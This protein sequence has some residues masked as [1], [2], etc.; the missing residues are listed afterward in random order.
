M[1][2]HF[3][4]K[5]TGNKRSEVVTIY[6]QI[7]FDNINTIVEPFCGSCAV[8][9]YIWTQNKDKNYKYILNDID[10][11]LI[12]LLRLIKEGNYKDVEDDVNKIREEILTYEDDM[13]SAKKIYLEYIK[14]NNISSYF[15]S[16][17][18]YAL[19]P[20]LFPS[21]KQDFK[22]FYSKI[23]ISQHPVYEFFTNADIE[24][25]NEDAFN[26]ID[27]YDYETSF[28]FLDPPYIERDNTN[29]IKITNKNISNIYETLYYKKLNNLKC[30]MMICHEYNWIFK[31]L[32]YDYINDDD[33]YQKIYSQNISAN[34]WR[35]K[36]YHICA[37]NYKN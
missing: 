29:Y 32:F 17:K 9:Y 25:Y 13:E 12:S 23:D 34:T 26:I 5:Y 20:A 18:Y 15:L 11:N 7:N 8:S 28:M 27:K 33:K 22:N 2:N 36:T 19:R 4:F 16:H 10:P 35:K 37:K 31:L 6:N 21:R 14:K 3:F 1:K 24:L 30:K